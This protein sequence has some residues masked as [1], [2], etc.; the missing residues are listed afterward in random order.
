MG[1]NGR[2]IGIL[3][4]TFNPIH[5]GHLLL[6][7]YALEQAGLDKVMIMPSG[8][9]YMKKD[10]YILTAEDRLKMAELSVREHL[11]FE[12]SDMEICRG[13][14]TYTYETLEELKRDNPLDE[15]YFIIGADCLYTIEKWKSPERIFKAC[16]ILSAVRDDKDTEQLQEQADYLKEK[17][18]AEICLLNFPRIDFSSSEIRE[19]IAKGKSI[20]YMVH[21]DVETYILEHKLF[22]NQI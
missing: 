10:M 3:G 6:A 2:K 17:F 22:L 16:T 11:D 14:Y 12:V 8:Q 1:D 13:G 19:R 7:Q 4:G 18:N 9:S 21:P 15:F 20:R 5:V